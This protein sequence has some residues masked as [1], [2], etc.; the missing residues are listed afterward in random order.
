MCLLMRAAKGVGV[1]VWL[2]GECS[3]VAVYCLL[4]NCAVVVAVEMGG[5]AVPRCIVRLCQH[6]YFSYV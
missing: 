4:T 5:T 6:T 2:R 3:K 1:F